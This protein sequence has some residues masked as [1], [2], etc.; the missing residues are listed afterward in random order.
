M[1]YLFWAIALQGR[2]IGII[3]NFA[4]ATPVISLIL[5]AIFL[6]ESIEINMFIGMLMIFCG[7]FPQIYRNLREN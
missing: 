1:G 6:K 3:S 7:I 2:V 5:P 4:Y